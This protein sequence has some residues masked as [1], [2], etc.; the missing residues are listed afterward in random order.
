VNVIAKLSHQSSGILPRRKFSS[1]LE[2]DLTNILQ[3]AF[4]SIYAYLIGARRRADSVK[5]GRNFELIS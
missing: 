3:T 2:V 4:A 1:S 5:N